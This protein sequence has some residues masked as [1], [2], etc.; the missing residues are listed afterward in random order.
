MRLE[1]IV[2]PDVYSLA[3]ML[4][5]DVEFLAEG[6]DVAAGK[7]DL[8]LAELQGSETQLRY[9]EKL[10]RARNSAVAVIPGPPELLSRD[11]THDKL[12]MV[13]NILRAAA[14]VWAYSPGLKVFCDGLIGSERTIVIPWPYDLVAT[15]R[16]GRCRETRLPDHCRVFIQLPLRFQDVTQNHP[17]VLKSVLLDVWDTLPAAV[18]DRLC[19]HTCVY[20]ERDRQQYYSSGFADGL[21]FVLEPRRSYRSFLRFLGQCQGVVNLTTGSIL[22]R[23]TFLSAALGRSGIFSKNSELNR[24]LYPDACVDLFDTV[25]LR[26]LLEK[27]FSG[28][29]KSVTDDGLLPSYDALTEIGDFRRNKTQLREICERISRGDDRSDDRRPEL[30]LEALRIKEASNDA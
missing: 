21:P 4:S 29:A 6:E 10:V 22:G 12:R 2:Y 16:W 23:V 30:N 14:Q 19:F 8:I 7:Y 20:T 17:F 18:R 25:R 5:G 24:R 15:Q 11:L 3:F 9:L 13:K 1:G 26:L 27:M 28:I